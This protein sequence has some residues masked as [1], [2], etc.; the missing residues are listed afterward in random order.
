[1][2]TSILDF[3]TNVVTPIRSGASNLTTIANSI[4]AELNNIKTD[5]TDIT[6]Y[7]DQIASAMTTFINQVKDQFKA[8][9]NGIST[10]IIDAIF[11]KNPIE[12][13]GKCKALSDSAVFLG[14]GVCNGFTDALS[15]FWFCMMILGIFLLVSF[16]ATVRTWKR[17]R[18]MDIRRR[19]VSG[20][21]K[22]KGDMQEVEGGIKS[23]VEADELPSPEVNDE[24]DERY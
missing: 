3:D 13:F 8:I 20:E 2:S 16:C 15:G 17:L 14:D 7:V 4:S 10:E 12:E 22:L 24:N 11:D 1:M 23:T 18:Y 19:S 21:Y 6:Q 9:L 5:L